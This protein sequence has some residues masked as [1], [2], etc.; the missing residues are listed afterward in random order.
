M[1]DLKAPRKLV[2]LTEGIV[3]RLDDYRFGHRI[4]RESDALRRLIEL[5]ATDLSMP[6]TGSSA[7]RARAV[8]LFAELAAEG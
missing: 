2:T 7:D 3:R 1:Q 5:G 4:G 8:A 6:I